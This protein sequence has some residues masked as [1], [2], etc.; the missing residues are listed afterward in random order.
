MPI[1][2]LLK[3]L[4]IIKACHPYVIKGCIGKKNRSSQ[5][6][7]KGKKKT[8]TRGRESPTAYTKFFL[9]FLKYFKLGLQI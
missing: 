4:L 8:K 9:F 3:G 1:H 2:I 5:N 7:T 6:R